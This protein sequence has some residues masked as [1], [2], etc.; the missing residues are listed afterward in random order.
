MKILFIG[1]TGNISSA[2]VERALALGYDVTL[3][4][5]GQHPTS[6]SLPVHS[7]VADHHD[8]A[9]LRTVAAE[10]RYDVVAE[11]IGYKPEDVAL[12]IEAF[13]GQVGQYVYIS[14]ASAY[15][16]PPSHY[17]ITE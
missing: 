2:C 9:A 6:F 16:K 13:R 1:G 3:L 12:D 11:F 14:S 10:G 15:Q 7:I 4:N 17:L 8:L 5:R